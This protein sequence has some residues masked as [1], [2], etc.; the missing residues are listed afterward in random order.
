[1]F[2]KLIKFIQ[3]ILLIILTAIYEFLLLTLYTILHFLGVNIMRF[4]KKRLDPIRVAL[5]RFWNYLVKKILDFIH[6]PH[7][8]LSY[9]FIFLR[10]KKNFF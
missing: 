3:K 8:K 5:I 2:I 9:I 7:T 4:E 10:G 6:L 1:M